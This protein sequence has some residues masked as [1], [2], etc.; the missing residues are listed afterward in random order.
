MVHPLMRSTLTATASGTTPMSREAEQDPDKI[1][2]TII[3]MLPR[4][5]VLVVGPG[6]GRDKLMHEVCRR[7]LRA[8]REQSTPFVVDADA[9]ALVSGDP[10]LVRGYELAVLTPNV[11][12]FGRLTGALG[13]DREV[14]EAAKES[15]SAKVEALARALGGVTVVQKG[16]KDLIS[17]GKRTL[18]VDLVGGRKRSGGQGD[19]LTGSIAAF[20]GWR[21]AYHDKIWETKGDISAEESMALAVFGGA[22]ITRVSS[23]FFRVS[24]WLDRLCYLH[25]G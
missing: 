16:A 7:V 15:E 10:D 19:T 8:A 17:N 5:H 18:V 20:L 3:D 9:L 21:K 1:A 13:I 24:E 2:A 12:E 4:I 25:D 11:V 23:L 14:S 22:S 6:L